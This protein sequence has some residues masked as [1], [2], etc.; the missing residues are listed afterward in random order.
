ML[1]RLPAPGMAELAAGEAAVIATK[2][3]TSTARIAYSWSVIVSFIS[4]KS[5]SG[6]RPKA[7]GV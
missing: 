2:A 3:P 6:P 7:P 4:L 5:A 1:G